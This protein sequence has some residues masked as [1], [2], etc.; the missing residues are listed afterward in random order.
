MTCVQQYKDSVT[1][2]SLK[3]KPQQRR[4]NLYKEKDKEFSIISHGCL[5][6]ACSNNSLSFCSDSPDTPDTISVAATF[7]I[8]SSSS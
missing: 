6:T 5:T 4:L 2:N 7:N 1:N 3:F 8:G